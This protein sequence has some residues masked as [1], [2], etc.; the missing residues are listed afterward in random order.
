M[1]SR[2]QETEAQAEL[3]NDEPTAKERVAQSNLPSPPLP[4]PPQTPSIEPDEVRSIESEGLQVTYCLGMAEVIRRETRYAR[5]SI[6]PHC[7]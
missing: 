1:T 5:P 7:G 3:P 2:S 6:D 4:S